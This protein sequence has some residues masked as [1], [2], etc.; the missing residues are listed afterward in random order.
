MKHTEIRSAVIDALEGAVG[1][2]VIYFDGRPAVIEE[3]DFPAIAVYL[4]DAEYTGEELDGD[5]WQATLH[6]EIFLPAQVPDSELDKWVET[7]IYPAIS[8]I[9]ALS[10][11]ITVM[12]PQ[13]YEYQRDDSLALWSSADLKYSINYEM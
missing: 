5:T 3:E 12:V 1:N 11:L 9:P 13:G 8:D 2:S 4:S 7:R 6:I 10:N